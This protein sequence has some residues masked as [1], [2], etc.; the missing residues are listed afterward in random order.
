M[1]IPVIERISEERK[2]PRPVCFPYPLRKSFFF[3]SEGI[4]IPS[5]SQVMTMPSAVSREDI[6]ILVMR[7]PP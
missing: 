4:P 5:F 6:R 7:S 1:V 2:R 3:S